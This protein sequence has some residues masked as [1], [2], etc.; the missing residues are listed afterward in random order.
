MP[1]LQPKKIYNV[2]VKAEAS[3]PRDNGNPRR[4]TKFINII[5]KTG[6]PPSIS[7]ARYIGIKPFNYGKVNSRDKFVIQAKIYASSS[8][9]NIKGGVGKWIQKRGFLP[10]VEGAEINPSADIWLV[11][12]GQ[13]QYDKSLNVLT[14]IFALKPFML[15]SGSMYE[16]QFQ[17]KIDG[18]EA[19]YSSIDLQVNEP[20]SSGFL[21]AYPE[22]AVALNT[23]VLLTTQN[24]QDNDEIVEYQFGY[25]I[26]A[27]ITSTFTVLETTQKTSISAIFAEG[28]G[29]NK[30]I[31]CSV[32]AIDIFGGEASA[33][34]TIRV[35]MPAISSAELMAK[36]TKMLEGSDV[37]DPFK[38]LALLNT[39]TTATNANSDK[40]QKDFTA[41]SPMRTMAPS[42][43]ATQDNS[44]MPGDDPN[45]AFVYV[46]PQLIPKSCP[47]FN[48]TQ[49]GGRGYCSK[50]LPDSECMTI[51]PSCVVQCDCDNGYF[52]GPLLACDVTAEERG[53]AIAFNS[54]ATNFLAKSLGKMEASI[55]NGQIQATTLSGMV[56]PELMDEES[57]ERAKN[58]SESIVQMSTK[59]GIS[60][61]SATSILSVGTLFFFGS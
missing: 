44:E 38:A 51:H 55:E 37:E 52:N 41:P 59:V 11:P 54:V 2:R 24:W 35:T 23:S 43:S 4:G 14:Q 61:R 34:A 10:T 16:F 19:T 49:C 20:P 28:Q 18:C 22:N 42:P 3:H 26:D 5:V 29:F 39:L 1:S 31:L 36:G 53:A 25:Y 9:Q 21:V 12:Y 6:A 32:K 27:D 57:L 17:I 45:S 56:M 7:L 33:F 50:S 46:P 58:I 40:K 13:T 15:S 60:S 48:G 47:I 8:C 30:T